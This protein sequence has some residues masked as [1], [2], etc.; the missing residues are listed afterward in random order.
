MNGKGV[1]IILRSLN[2]TGG[3][4]EYTLIFHGK[5]MP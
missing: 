4:E 2:Y 5:I 3:G 1:S